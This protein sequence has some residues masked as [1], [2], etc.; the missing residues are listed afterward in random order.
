MKDDDFHNVDVLLVEDSATDA[1]FVLRVLKKSQ[2]S[3]KVYW[4]KDG[5]EAL[6]FIFAQKGYAERKAEDFPKVIL[7]DLKLP[8]IDGFGVLKK[9][10]SDVKTVS[11]PIVMMTSS[12]EQKDILSSYQLGVNS[13]VVKPLNFSKFTEAMGKIGS[14]WLEVNQVSST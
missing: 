11:I 9:I 6:D 2:T 1:S 12:K 4:V 3:Y 10:K 5:A 8:K 14:Y 7:L 13:Y